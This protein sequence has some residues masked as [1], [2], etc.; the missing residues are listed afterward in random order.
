L[1]V[2]ANRGRFGPR[3]GLY[4]VHP[5]PLASGHGVC[6]ADRIRIGHLGSVIVGV[7]VIG[8]PEERRALLASY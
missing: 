3:E 6:P 1:Q 4:E 7:S 8:G 2:F 5:E